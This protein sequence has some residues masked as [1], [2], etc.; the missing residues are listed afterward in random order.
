MQPEV[1]GAKRNLGEGTQEEPG[2]C[3]SLCKTFLH[4]LFHLHPISSYFIQIDR[5]LESKE[6]NRVGISNQEL[7]F[8]LTF[9]MEQE[10]R[11]VLRS[12]ATRYL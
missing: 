7:H 5:A 10:K 9:Q 12:N 6:V 8:G 2:W 3:D 11:A 1:G 4:G